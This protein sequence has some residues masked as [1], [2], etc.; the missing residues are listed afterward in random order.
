MVFSGPF[1]PIQ[2]T[3]YGNI[4]PQLSALGENSTSASCLVDFVLRST[5]YFSRYLAVVSLLTTALAQ[6]N[7]T[8]V[9][10]KLPACSVSLLSCPKS[11]KPSNNSKIACAEKLLPP[12]GCAFG[13]IPHCLC[14][15]V[16]LQGQ[17][18]ACVHATCNLS[19]QSCKS[20]PLYSN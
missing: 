17:L 13:D 4:N 5:M 3:I 16:T 8:L 15:N 11:R 6:F 9:I 7:L 2:G 19:E 14:T 12:A 18:T 20:L 10:S 1:T